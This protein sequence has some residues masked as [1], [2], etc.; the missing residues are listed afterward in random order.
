MAC[1]KV[2]RLG[3]VCQVSI[4]DLVLAPAVALK[5][6][7]GMALHMMEASVCLGTVHTTGLIDSSP[8]SFRGQPVSAWYGVG[9]DIES[10][11]GPG[12]AQARRHNRDGD[13]SIEHLGSHEVAEVVEPEMTKPGTAAHPD[14][15]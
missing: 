4:G 13:S 3:P 10:R 2:Y 6:G 8:Q 7:Y 11:G 12:M 15:A 14:K 9:V 5:C 1:D